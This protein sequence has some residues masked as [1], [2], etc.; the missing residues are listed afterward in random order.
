MTVFYW[1]GNKNSLEFKERKAGKGKM[2][3]YFDE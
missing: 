3:Q 1:I 2:Y